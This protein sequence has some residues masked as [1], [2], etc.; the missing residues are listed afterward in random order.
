MNNKNGNR[1]PKLGY[2][3]R[4]SRSNSNS[5]VLENIL[6]RTLKE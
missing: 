3:F 6:L 2:D 4:N 5:Y 1:K